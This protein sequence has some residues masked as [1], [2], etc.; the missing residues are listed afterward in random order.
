M[1]HLNLLL[2]ITGLLFS[3]FALGAAAGG[4]ADANGVGPTNGLAS[5]ALELLYSEKRAKNCLLGGMDLSFFNK[6]VDF[7]TI[8][9]FIDDL[10]GGS[11]EDSSLSEEEAQKRK[12]I[13][14][15]LFIET[16]LKACAFGRDDILAYFLWNQRFSAAPEPTLR[17]Q[18]AK[19]LMESSLY[20]QVLDEKDVSNCTLLSFEIILRGLTD[21]EATHGSLENVYLPSGEDGRQINLCPC[22]THKTR[23]ITFH[24]LALCLLVGKSPKCYRLLL[25]A[26]EALEKKEFSEEGD[27]ERLQKFRRSYSLSNPRH[28]SWLVSTAIKADDAE[29]LELLILAGAPFAVPES[30][31][32]SPLIEASQYASVNCFR[33]LLEYGADPDQTVLGEY[34]LL[35]TQNSCGS[36]AKNFSNQVRDERCDEIKRMIKIW[37]S[38]VMRQFIRTQT[39]RLQIRTMLLSLQRKYGE[40]YHSKRDEALKVVSALAPVGPFQDPHSMTARNRRFGV[41]KTYGA[42]MTDPEMNEN[43]CAWL[44]LVGSFQKIAKES[45]VD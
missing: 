39:Q 9:G 13:Q 30:K 15:T 33:L 27:K 22:L 45:E 36:E 40:G 32:S 8:K 19:V 20:Q 34:Y 43:E 21:K 42:R 35:N 6:D 23:F 25:K 29:T 38:R 12:R 16:L 26:Y 17:H 4:G 7:E 31:Y 18:I 10:L 11:K 44:A 28:A 37:P 41:F 1:K 2:F 3:C 5:L 24:P 14:G